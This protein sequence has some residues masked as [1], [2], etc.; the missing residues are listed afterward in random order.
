MLA[1]GLQTMRRNLDYRSELALWQAT[2]AASP[3]KARPWTNLGYAR[4]LQG[5]LDGAAAA[6][7]CALAQDPAHRQAAWNLAAIAPGRVSPGGDDC[8][9]TSVAD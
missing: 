4:Q 9:P 7:R 6:Y 1:A 8:T 2:V 3:G 5:D